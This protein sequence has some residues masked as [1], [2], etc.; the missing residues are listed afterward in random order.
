MEEEEARG[1]REEKEDPF[2]AFNP[3]DPTEIAPY[4]HLDPTEITF[5]PLEISA[6]SSRGGIAERLADQP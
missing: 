5:L 3:V 4:Y 1:G 6:R 2:A